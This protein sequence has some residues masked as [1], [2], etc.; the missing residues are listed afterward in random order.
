MLAQ[1]LTLLEDDVSRLKASFCHLSFVEKLFFRADELE[2]SVR[3]CPLGRGLAVLGAGLL[4]CRKA[5][6]KHL[7]LI[8]CDQPI[9]LPVRFS[10]TQVLFVSTSLLRE[11]YINGS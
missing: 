5:Q 11:L 6:F 8:G 7:N 10:N 2:H 1:T 4:E 9:V 3:A